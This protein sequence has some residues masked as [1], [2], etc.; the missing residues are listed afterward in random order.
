[1][2][3]AASEP[4]GAFSSGPVSLRDAALFTDLYELTMARSYFNEGMRARATFSL[5]VRRLPS[6]RAF[7]IAAGL[8][9]VLH[10]LETFRFSTAA[11][12][13]LR[14]LGQFDAGFLAFLRDLR[15]TGDVRAVP[16]GTPL[17]PDEPLLEVSAPIIEA[18][19]VETAVLNL[20]HY[21][22]VVASKAARSVLAARGRPVVEFGLRRAPG[23]DGGMKAARSSFL[24]GAAAS[25]N[26]LA[27]RTYG[28]A[29]SGTMAHSYVTAFSREIDA[30]R[31]FVRTFPTAPILLIDTYDT[32]AGAHH[33]VLVARE[34][35]ARGQ[36]LS[37]VRLDSGDI[38][39]L[40][41][42]V[43]AILDGANLS[44]VRIFVSGGLDESDIEEFLARGVPIDA[45]GIGTRMDVSAD[46]PYF[47]MAYKLVQYD[48]RQVL[49]TS[50]GKK[51]WPGEKQVW[52]VRAADGRFDHDVIGLRDEAPPTS[53]ATA[54]LDSV[55][56]SGRIVAPAPAV[57]VIRDR[58]AAQLAALPDPVRRIRDAGVY[59]VRYSDRLVALQ[60]RTE[61]E[62][63]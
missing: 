50:E 13:Y 45:F 59:S 28:L 39:E 62:T 38:V 35:E 18:Q 9:D 8:E 40:S 26:T 58:C 41:K 5:F 30:F 46:A 29:P 24:A 61:A 34:M 37:G 10:F 33:A 4:A 54:L 31:A 16:E 7:L 48:G 11:L 52:R 32:I 23:L 56:A 49:K 1:M 19:L 51:T 22:S 63:H 60:R 20:C 47:D 43:R 14:S 42:A 25:S 57:P 53:G 6:S 21:P 15:F 17:F 2:K 55:M 27:G 44:Y 36:R 3:D 12:E